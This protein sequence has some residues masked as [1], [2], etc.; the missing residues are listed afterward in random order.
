[1][2]DEAFA[3]AQPGTAYTFHLTATVPFRCAAGMLR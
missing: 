1:V 3:L 2:G